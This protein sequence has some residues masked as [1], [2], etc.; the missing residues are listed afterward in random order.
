MGA[1][2]EWRFDNQKLSVIITYNTNI[3]K[4]NKGDRL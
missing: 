4:F 2:K 1:I 3:Y